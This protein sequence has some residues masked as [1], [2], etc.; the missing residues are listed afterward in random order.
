MLVVYDFSHV[1]PKHFLELRPKKEVEFRIDLVSGMD[2][3]AKAPY[4]LAPPEMLE[5]YIQHQ[6]LLDK[7]FIRST[8]SP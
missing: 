2:L 1:F 3:I 8:S 7:R 5:L 6:E 4:R